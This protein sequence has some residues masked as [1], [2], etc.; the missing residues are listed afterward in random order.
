[1]CSEEIQLVKRLF[2]REA[3]RNTCKW[4]RPPDPE[5][6]PRFLVPKVAEELPNYIRIIRYCNTAKKSRFCPLLRLHMQARVI[7]TQKK[8]QRKYKITSH[9]LSNGVALA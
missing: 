4:H 3:F 8:I 7:F 9:S 2:R 1:M 6:R 5:T